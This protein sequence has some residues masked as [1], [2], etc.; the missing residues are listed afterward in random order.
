MQKPGTFG[1][2]SLTSVVNKIIGRFVIGKIFTHPQ[3]NNLIGASLDGFG[4]KGSSLT[5]LLGFAC[6]IDSYDTDN[7]KLMDFINQDFQKVFDEV[8]H[9]RLLAKAITYGI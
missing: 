3:G 9:E 6:V 4:N 7:N 2:I 8:Q 1:P 5:S